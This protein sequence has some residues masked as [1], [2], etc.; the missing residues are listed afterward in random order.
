MSKKK[1]RI[2]LIVAVVMLVATVGVLV[3]EFAIAPQS[4]K[5]VLPDLP[6]NA[7]PA[8]VYDPDL[9]APG[10]VKAMEKRLLIPGTIDNEVVGDFFVTA[11]ETSHKRGEEGAR[12]SLI[13]AS[14]QIMYGRALT[15]LGTRS[16]FLKWA[17][18]FDL[19]FR[20]SGDDFHAAI[21]RSGNLPGDAYQPFGEHWSVTLAYTRALLE[22][23]RAF[24]GK[25]LAGLIEVQSTQ[26]LPLFKDNKTAGELVAGPKM[27]LGYDEWEDPPP[28]DIP[29]PGDDPPVETASGTY[30]A[31]IDLWALYALSRFDPGW[32]PIASF[33]H[34]AVAE[35]RLDSELPLYASAIE[36]G[37]DTYL[38]VTGGGLCSQ[39]REQLEIA[40]HLAE[41]GTVDHDFIS[42]IRS[43][44]RDSKRLPVGWNPVT[45]GAQG[46][47]AVPADYGMSLSLGR[48]SGDT[49]LVDSAR[50]VMMYSY[51][52]STTS[53]IFG[54]WFR[55]G[56]SSRTFKLVAE[57]NTVVLLALR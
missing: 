22:G 46:G 1:Q 19:A 38:A 47:F 6:G 16:G 9:L 4:G 48:A 39:T 17:R 37:K 49:L 32:A 23:Y 28:G 55:P 14:D 20:C 50:E 45:G 56:E 41:V 13:K 51:A 40:L 27:L 15:R 36:Q 11:Y 3:Y 42:F 8:S 30:L 57:D 25:T 7:Q 31:D 44:L 2:L 21:L 29:E 24:G 43:Q 26:L 5:R 52:S 35:S 34:K 10:I 12:I 53:D 33:W 18:S 54:G